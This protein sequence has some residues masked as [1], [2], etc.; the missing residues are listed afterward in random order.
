[1]NGRRIGGAGGAGGAVGAVRA[2]RVVGAVLGLGALA[3]RP[4][5]PS[6]KELSQG[7]AIEVTVPPAPPLLAGVDADTVRGWTGPGGKPFEVTRRTGADGH[8]YRK[9]GTRTLPLPLRTSAREITQYP[10][11]AC[12]QG[13]RLTSTQ[14]SARHNDIDAVHPSATRGA[15]STCHAAGAVDRL[16]LPLGALA[17]LDQPYRLCAQCH[18]GQV[19]AWAAGMHGK[20]MD[21][22][23]GRRVIMNCTDCHDPHTPRT[24]ARI[25]FPGARLPTTPG[26]HK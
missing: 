23:G 6:Y 14:E 11:S 24:E 10:C 5:L 21:G 20:R 8:S 13:G 25:P 22:W 7:E 17:T 19:A 1:M 15:C 18:S 26:G 16:A 9:F 3:C 2:V 4:E 12:H